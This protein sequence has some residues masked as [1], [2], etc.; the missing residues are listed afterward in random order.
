M[1]L[2]AYEWRESC[3]GIARIFPVEA[4]LAMC[5]RQGGTIFLSEQATTKKGHF[6]PGVGGGGT[7]TYKCKKNNRYNRVKLICRVHMPL[8]HLPPP[9]PPPHPPG[10]YAPGELLKVS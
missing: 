6:L 8:T 9:P 10:C 2:C 5:F 3:S 4:S 1:D 7:T